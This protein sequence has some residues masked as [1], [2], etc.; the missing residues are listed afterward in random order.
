MTK[1]ST[2]LKPKTKVTILYLGHISPSL[3]VQLLQI[4]RGISKK[5]LSAEVSHAGLCLRLNLKTVSRSRFQKL[6]PLLNW[7]GTIVYHGEED[8]SRCLENL[9]GLL[10]PYRGTKSSTSTSSTQ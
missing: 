7:P 9:N 3:L 10:K 6:P 4:S 8:F 5:T 2:T 1:K